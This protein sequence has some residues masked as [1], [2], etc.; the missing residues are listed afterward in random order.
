MYFLH[1]TD[2]DFQAETLKYLY[3]LFGPDDVLPLN[4]IV[5][6]TEAHPLPVFDMGKMFKTGWERQPRNATG[7]IVKSSATRI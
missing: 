4:Q 2:Y 5:L 6:N 7:D 1:Q 3:L